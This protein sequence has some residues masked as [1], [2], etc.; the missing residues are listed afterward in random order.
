MSSLANSFLNI[1]VQHMLAASLAEI[2]QALVRNPF[3]VVKQNLQVGKYSGMLECG[4][5]IFKHKGLGGLY[6]GYLSFI[7]RE[8]PFSS[9]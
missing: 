6:N 4:M 7:M 5:D 2:S 9:I 1:N 8:I 3:E